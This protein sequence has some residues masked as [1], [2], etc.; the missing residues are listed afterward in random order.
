MRY[1][2]ILPKSVQKK[3]DRLPD[4]IANRVLV[5]L[6]ALET[7]PRPPD[8]KKLKGRNGWRIRISDYRVI[9]EIQDPALQV[10]VI[11]LGHRREVYH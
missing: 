8:V 2:V 11:T 5:R 4:D 7:N 6:A 1:R 3:L 10:L 9:Y